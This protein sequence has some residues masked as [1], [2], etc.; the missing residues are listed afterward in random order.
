[1]IIFRNLA[2]LL[3]NVPMA[4]TPTHR[5]TELPRENERRTVTERGVTL[6][7]RYTPS[8]IT[9]THHTLPTS[10]TP[11]HFS[12]VVVDDPDSPEPESPVYDHPHHKRERQSTPSSTKSVSGSTTHCVHVELLL[13][14][15]IDS[16]QLFG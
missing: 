8:H 13:A 16:V 11:S 5:S 6:S 2:L 3:T 10:H 7:Y 4:T 14:L 15:L 9:H 12:Q 1:M